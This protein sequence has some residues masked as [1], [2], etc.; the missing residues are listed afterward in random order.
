MGDL[1]AGFLD[2]QP[3]NTA[4]FAEFGNALI[5]ASDLD[6]GQVKDMMVNLWVRILLSRVNIPV[7]PAS[8]E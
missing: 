1:N 2:M 4:T 7:P 5:E 8:S 3:L 6:E